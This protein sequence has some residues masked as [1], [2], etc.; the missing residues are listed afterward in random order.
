MTE[1]ND[2]D[3]ERYYGN[4]E[5]K[6]QIT[7]KSKTLNKTQQKKMTGGEKS[8]MSYNNDE[9]LV[10]LTTQMKFRLQEGA[11]EAFYVIGVGDKGDATGISKEYM[12]ASLR[13]LH[14]MSTTLEAH[15]KIVYLNKGRYGEIV[16]IR[17]N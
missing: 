15:I 1:M 12:E 7:C 6:L 4:T 3:E 14:K 9:R 8:R 5:Y 13:N 2:I 11:G 10:K 16:K 17:V